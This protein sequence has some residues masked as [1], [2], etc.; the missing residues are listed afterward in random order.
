MRR[1]LILFG[2]VVVASGR[3]I[4]VP[5]SAATIQAGLGMAG[6]GD[7]VLVRP[8]TYFENI[9]WPATD[10]IK[11]Y[12]MAG[13]DSTVVDGGGAGV[14]L[15]MNSSTLT[16][17][18]EVRGFT[19]QNGFGPSGAGGIL[20]AGS[21]TIAGNRITRCQG[22]G[23]YLQSYSTNFR[24]L[25]TGN[26]I[27]GCVKEVTWSYG[28]GVYLDAPQ[29]AQPEI[30]YNYIHHD[31]LRNGPWNYGGGI[32]C[33]AEALIYQNVIAFNVLYSDTGSNCRAYG[34]G[35]FVD[36]NRRPL[37]FS[38]LIIGNRCA[39]DAWKYGA[40]IRLYLGAQPVIINNTIVDNVCEGPH[41]W[42]NGGG[43]YSDMRCTSYVKHN[44]IAN[45][46]A[47]SGSGI[48]NFTMTQ[49]G[50]VI[51]RYN[52][53]YNNTLVGC[54]MGPGDIN[55]DP[56]F[57]SGAHGNYYLSQIAAGQGQ[58]SPCL[59]AGDTLLMTLPLNLDSLLRTWTTRTDSVADA[60]QLDMGYHYPFA[61]PVGLAEELRSAPRPK[62]QA[63]P[64]LVRDRV[65]FAPG[66]DGLL[67]LE[68]FDPAGRL[69]YQAQGEGRLVWESGGFARGVY[70]YLITGP[71]GRVSGRLVRL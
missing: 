14:C 68:V 56:L 58:N 34:A 45:N 19:F 51:S 37:I 9:V 55:L 35:I 15:V 62:A 47:T 53:Y 41:M 54:S 63:A 23:I 6:F 36:M 24:P 28:G 12:S 5:D 26:E 4:L 8:G 38:N 48:Y 31:T 7:T 22:S 17:A 46:Q 30:C 59:D 57:V 43:I 13:P 2:L 49:N 64:S 65:V 18:T 40:G 21:A 66:L 42:S 67:L 52:D 61:L 70:H 39:T 20:C 1:L 44:I 10:G 16:R 25:V 29:G 32:Y 11:L 69:V 50:E 33:D 60:G 27:D 71:K 3:V